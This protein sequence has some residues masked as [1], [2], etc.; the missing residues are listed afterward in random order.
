[1]SSK[2]D[3]HGV[4]RATVEGDPGVAN[5]GLDAENLVVRG[6]GIEGDDVR[7]TFLN[8][9]LTDAQVDEVLRNHPQVETSYDL[10]NEVQPRINYM[11][12]LVDNDRMGGET[13][14][15]CVVRQPQSLERRFQSVHEC[16]DYVAV[17]KPWCVRLDTP[18]GWP[19][20]TRFTAKY[21]GDLSVEDWL[22]QKYVETGKWDT[23]RFCHQLDNA[24]SGVLLSA[25]NKKAA[26]AAARLFRETSREKN[27]PGARFWPPDG[28]RVDGHGAAGKGPV[29]PQGVQ[30]KS[31]GICRGG[32]EGGGDVRGQSQQQSARE[33]VRDALRGFIARRFD[34]PRCVFR[35]ARRESARDA[36][37]GS[38][39][40]D[41]RA[42][43]AQRAP[44]R[45]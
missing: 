5:P 37:D 40:P 16:D 22:E 13:V 35:R 33:G 15:E 31:R 28:R 1:M 18:R 2:R 7:S 17:N 38:A 19:G 20:K 24:T 10:V 30:G 9:G 23:V 29:R 34:A 44:D 43:G 14:A 27:L 11:R 32:R 8:A 4:A 25:A 45:G 26:G 41:P 42:F 36:V 12:F 21:P 39:P 3:R 6:E